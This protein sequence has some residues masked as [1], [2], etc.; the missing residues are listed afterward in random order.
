[1][2]KNAAVVIAALA[3]MVGVGY[4]ITTRPVAV[5]EA[6]PLGAAASPEV[7]NFTQFYDDIAVGGSTR[8]TS[9]VNSAETLLAADFDTEKFIDYTP[10]VQ[11]LTLT[12]P[13]S[14]TL[15]SFLPRAGMTRTIYIRNATTTS[16]ASI[17]ITIAG[18]TGTLLKVATTT[19]KIF[20][21]TDAA[22]YGII[23]FIRKGNSDIEAIFN[24]VTD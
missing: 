20:S 19:K 6:P 14:T 22:N 15:R 13:A 10:N 7:Y 11:A 16:T 21:D 5:Q 23:T 2:I 1:M 17:D 18:N 12:L 8:A 24:S 9:T 4:L 3:V